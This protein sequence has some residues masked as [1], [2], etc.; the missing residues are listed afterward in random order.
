LAVHRETGE[1]FRSDQTVT[2]TLPRDTREL[3]ARTWLPIVRDFQMRRGRYRA[4]IVVRDAAS[5]K[6]GTVSHDFEVPEVA[7]FRASTPVLSDLKEK[8]P[9]G[10]EQLALMARRDFAQGTALFCQLEGSGAGR[11]GDP[12]L[13][14]GSMGYEVRKSDGTLLTRDLPSLIAPTARGAVSRMI[15]FSLEAASPGDYELSMRI[16]DE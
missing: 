14:R 15:G 16:R 13:P 12:G 8:T 11:L 3:L 5:G 9:D 2:L 1:L 6:V 10:G 7:Q 4:K